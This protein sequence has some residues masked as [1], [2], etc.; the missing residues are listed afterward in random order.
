MAFGAKEQEVLAAEMR[1]TPVADN[2]LPYRLQRFAAG[3]PAR[4]IQHQMLCIRSTGYFKPNSS[5]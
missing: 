2:V 5:E 4:K 1:F 3:G